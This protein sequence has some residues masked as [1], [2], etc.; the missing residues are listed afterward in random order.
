[1]TEIA[2]HLEQIFND[3]LSIGYYLTH[4]RQS[5]I[6]ILCNLGGN[7][8]YINPKNY[9][10]IS[11]VNTI[12]KIIKAII[13]AGISF[14]ATIYELLLTTFFG[15]RR[16]SCVETAI[17]HLLEKIYAAGNDNKIASLLMMDVFAEYP[18]TSHQRLLHNLRK[19]KIDIK[20]VDL[21]AS[22]QTDRHTIV[23]TNKNITP[24]LSINLGLPQ[25][26]LPSS[27][28][29]LSDNM[30]LSNDFAK[31]KMDAQGYIDDITLTTTGKS[32]KSNSQKLAK[33]HNE[34]CKN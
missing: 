26:S 15:D 9:C 16:G 2:G 18:N 34:V 19:R 1:M 30:D 3:S 7:R 21:V 25:G 6:I 31:K 23:K 13:A 32:V 22:F 4:F 12:G 11:L 33:V 5:V 29:Y 10:L 20:M 8:D 24:K 27:I 28:L 17:H 14:M